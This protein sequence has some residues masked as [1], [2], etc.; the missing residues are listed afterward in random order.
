[1]LIFYLLLN[2]LVP[3]VLLFFGCL[4]SKRPPAKIN[5]AYGY[6]TKASMKSEATWLFAHSYYGRILRISG[7]IL[8]VIAVV[9]LLIFRKDA[10]WVILW[11]SVL[12]I[13][14]LLLSV[15][16]TETA[17]RQKFDKDGIPRNKK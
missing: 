2:S 11:N 14:T 8:L 10:L 7:G 4:W 6:R 1:M 3:A 16:P 15:I 13:L 12:Q 9:S 5:W 17:L